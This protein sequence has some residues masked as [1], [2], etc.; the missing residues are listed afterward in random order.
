MKHVS[1]SKIGCSD[2]ASF[3]KFQPDV[4]HQIPWSPAVDFIFCTVGLG[5]II[6]IHWREYPLFPSSSPP[7][8]PPL[9]LLSSSPPPLPHLLSSPPSHLDY[10]HWVGE[11]HWVINTCSWPGVRWVLVDWKSPTVIQ[12]SQAL[13][14]PLTP[15]VS[16]ESTDQR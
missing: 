6:Q 15:P 16:T 8:L 12:T 13:G 14:G 9:P 10:E 1:K 5:E 4:S 2:T 11:S 7:P 3:S